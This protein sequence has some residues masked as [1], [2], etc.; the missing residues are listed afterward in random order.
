M[1]VNLLVMMG[2]LEVVERLGKFM[3]LWANSTKRILT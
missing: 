1:Y 2:L 3:A